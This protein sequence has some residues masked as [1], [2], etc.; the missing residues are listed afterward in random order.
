LTFAER[1]DFALCR[2]RGKRVWQIA[3]ALGRSPATITRELRRNAGRDGQYRATDA[4]ARAYQRASR[5]KSA[6]LAGNP[7]L[8][9]RV[10]ADLKKRYSPE[11]ITGRLRAEFSDDP[12]MRVCPDTIYQSL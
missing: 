9:G 3:T 12:E 5:A 6:K 11:Q 2:A 8:R 4:H 7:R 1:E 10:D